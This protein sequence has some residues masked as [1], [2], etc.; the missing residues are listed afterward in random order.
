[1]VELLWDDGDLGKRLDQIGPQLFRNLRAAMRFIAEKHQ[2]ALEQRH[3]GIPA[4][5]GLIPRKDPGAPL[6]RT[7]GR[8]L[9]SAGYEITPPDTDRGRA[10]LGQL[11]LLRFIGR[12]VPYA[13]IQEEGGE[14]GPVS[15]KIITVPTRFMRTQ[16]GDVRGR[17]IHFPGFW[18]KNKRKNTLYFF[19]RDTGEPLFKGVGPGL[20]QE[21]VKL[22]PRLGF[23]SLFK[24][25]REGQRRLLEH[26][27]KRGL[28]GK[29]LA[30]GGTA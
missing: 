11:Q 30:S 6:S 26:A 2:T 10:A 27:I 22:P 13:R 4:S 23:V 12:G 5:G 14:I 1:M 19:H 29:R 18:R 9:E 28:E 20:D 17:A 3:R 24:A 8:L 25:Q 7:T 16:G 15:R 21:T